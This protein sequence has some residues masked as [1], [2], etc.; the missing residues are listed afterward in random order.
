MLTRVIAAEKPEVTA[1]SFAPGVVNTA[2]QQNI[3]DRKEMMPAQL[4]EYF[5]ALHSNDQLEP[6]EVPGRALA[7]CALN[8]PR[9][10]TGN[11]IQYSDPSLVEQVRKAFG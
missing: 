5:Q 3:R 4:A 6:P 8:A 11:E 10:W 7:W 2:M 9:E 1:F